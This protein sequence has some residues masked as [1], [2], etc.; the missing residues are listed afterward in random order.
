[1]GGERGLWWLVM[2]VLGKMW[3]RGMEEDEEGG[4]RWENGEK[5]GMRYDV[6]TA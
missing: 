4:W 3:R 1:M 5:G 2:W 6:I